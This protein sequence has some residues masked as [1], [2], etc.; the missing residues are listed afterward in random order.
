MN[1][2]EVYTESISS[3][4][5]ITDDISFRIKRLRYDNQEMTEEN[6]KMIDGLQK[7]LVETENKLKETLT[8]SKEDSIKVKCGWARW[9]ILKDK[10]VFT[11]KTIEEV[12]TKYPAEADRYIKTEKSLKLNPLK[13]D[14]E[15]GEIVI[16]NMSKVPQEKKFEYKYKEI[17]LKN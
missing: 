5:K 8:G 4:L 3:L 12:E 1:N 13:K 2:G 16:E 6:D 9:K 7:K 15:S 11:D 14:I 10:I 17:K